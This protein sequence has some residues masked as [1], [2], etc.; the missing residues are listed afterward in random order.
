MCARISSSATRCSLAVNSEQYAR[1]RTVFRELSTQAKVHTTLKL[2]RSLQTSMGLATSERAS[3]G[4]VLMRVPKSTAI[5]LDYSAGLLLPASALWPRLR[6]AASSS[7]EPLPWDILH[8][9]ALVDGLA[10]DG[11][12]FWQSYCDALLPAPEQLTLPMCWEAPRLA[13]LQHADIAA[14]AAAQQARLSGLFPDLM[15]PLAPD[16]PSWFQWAFACVRSR[17]FRAGPD[18]FAFV[19]FLDFANHAE[20]PTSAAAPPTANGAPTANADF[21]VSPP[22][23]AA[24]SGGGGSNGSGG[25]G[26]EFFELVALRDIAHDEEVTICYSGPEG[27]TNQRYMAQYGFV[28]QGGNPADRIKL[29]LEPQLQA[30]PL[31]LARLQ[32]LMGDALF[33]AALR[34]TDPY[35]AAALKSLP[36]RDGPEEGTDPRVAGAPGQQG[37]GGGGG[38]ASMRTAAALLEQ[39][40]A[41]MAEGTTALEADEEMLAGSA[42]EALWAAD[43]RLAAAVSYRVE[44]K[45][46]LAKGEALLKAY[47]RGSAR[48]R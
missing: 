37:G 4:D 35:L 9:L 34:G 40:R 22:L 2:G 43:P 5:V 44:R 8:S 25:G 10:G 36:L 26:G 31:E 28:P 48:F 47:L 11:G 24:G 12:D 30:A 27:Y 41:Q 38:D 42:G 23:A 13:Q 18:A 1:T 3:A 46:L 32:G 29:E 15:E 16:V 20:A 19:P 14:A 7:P 33:L 21:R 6:G 17:A 45:R 39:V